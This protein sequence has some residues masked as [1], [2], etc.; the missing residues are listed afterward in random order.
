LKKGISS[1]K[2]TI[3]FSRFIFEKSKI[4]LVDKPPAV[5]FALPNKK[6]A[7]FKGKLRYKKQKNLDGNRRPLTFALL[8]KK[9]G[10][11]EPKDL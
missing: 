8:N 4:N 1:K 11:I 6:G 2:C 3:R 5:T 9:R 10:K 7:F